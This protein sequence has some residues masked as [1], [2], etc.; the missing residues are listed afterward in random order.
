MYPVP[1]YVCVLGCGG[2]CVCVWVCCL[3]WQENTNGIT[4]CSVVKMGQYLAITST[5]FDWFQL[6][7]GHRCNMRTCICWWGRRSHIKDK[8]HLYV[9]CVCVCGEYFAGVQCRCLWGMLWGFVNFGGYGVSGNE[10][11]VNIFVTYLLCYWC[12][13]CVID[14]KIVVIQLHISCIFAAMTVFNKPLMNEWMNDNMCGIKVRCQ[15]A[16]F[17]N[18][19]GVRH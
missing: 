12:L 18:C 8:F 2:R 9:G 15:F 13:Y 14:C 7:V 5:C 6:K 3:P 19:D 17:T 4:L 10:L 11:L 1:R 16:S